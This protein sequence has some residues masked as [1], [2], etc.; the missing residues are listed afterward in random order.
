MLMVLGLIDPILAMPWSRER[1]RKKA[2]MFYGFVFFITLA[3]NIIFFPMTN[4]ESK[5]YA[6]FF[7]CL[8]LLAIGLISPR[9]VLPWSRSPSKAA[10]AMFYLP[11]ALILIGAMVYAGA[12]N[13]VDPRYDVPGGDLAG[14]DPVT[15]VKYLAAAELRGD[16]NIGLERVRKID[17]KETPGGGLDVK[18]EYNIE[19]VLMKELFRAKAD[20]DMAH[21]YKALYTGGYDVKNVTI[22]A[23]Y[24]VGDRASRPPPVPIFTTS[25]DSG[26]ASK[27]D[28]QHHMFELES[29]ILPKLW[30]VKFAH[31]DFR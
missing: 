14:V 15:A 22:T 4:L 9:A 28:W 8:I 19:D 23:Y 1:S 17:V 25:L 10:V 16:N 27:V 20:S 18:V 26:A 5:V 2:V 21:V 6:L 12:A 24:P 30:K 13:P 7:F 29:D 31:Q 3:L 11:P